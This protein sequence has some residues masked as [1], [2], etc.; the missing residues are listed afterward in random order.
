MQTSIREYSESYGGAG[1]LQTVAVEIDVTVDMTS[2]FNGI[3]KVVFTTDEEQEL[4]FDHHGDLPGWIQDYSEYGLL[5]VILED[6]IEA[7]ESHGHK[8]AYPDGVE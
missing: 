7:V 6:A 3:H 8:V 4:C 5:Q 2:G 1:R